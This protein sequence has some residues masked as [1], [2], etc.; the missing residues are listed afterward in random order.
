MRQHKRWWTLL[1]SAVT[2]VSACDSTVGVDDFER[3]DVFGSGMVVREARIVA[4]FTGVRASG[5]HTVV[6]EQAEVEGV[7]V[8]TDDNLVAFVWTDVIDGTL[9]VSVDPQVRLR[10]TEPLIVRIHAGELSTLIADGAISL[11]ADIGSVPDLN[12]REGWGSFHLYSNPI[13]DT[14]TLSRHSL[15]SPITDHVQLRHTCKVLFIPRD[16]R[17]SESQSRRGNPEVVGVDQQAVFSQ[18]P[19]QATVAPG[20]LRRTWDHLEGRYQL[21]PRGPLVH[22]RSGRQLTRDCEG[23][24]ELLGLV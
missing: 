20:N 23:D 22:S 18:V 8:T 17:H 14:S 19:I 13:I 12:V 15:P 3:T 7:E 6:V 24:V 4:S 11:D 1:A 16:H 9:V 10:P 5:G 2:A 21:I